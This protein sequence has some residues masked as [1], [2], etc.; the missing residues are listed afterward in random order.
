MKY[1]THNSMRRSSWV[2]KPRDAAGRDLSIFS[3]VP[4][5]PYANRIQNFTR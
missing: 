5:L 1:K 3:A 2:V 4:A